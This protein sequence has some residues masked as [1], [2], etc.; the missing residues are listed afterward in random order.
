MARERE[1]TG[2]REDPVA[3]VGPRRPPRLHERG[4]RQLRLDREGEHRPLVQGVGVVNDG[5]RIPRQPHVREDVEERIR[6][7][8]RA[9][10]PSK[11]KS[12]G[13]RCSNHRRSCSGASWRNSGV[14]S[15]GSSSSWPGSLSASSTLYSTVCSPTGSAPRSGFGSMPN[16]ARGSGSANGSSSSSANGSPR[17]SGCDGSGAATGAVPAAAP[18]AG[19]SRSSSGPYSDSDPSGS[20][21]SSSSS[22]PGAS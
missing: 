6:E 2:H 21:Y 8:R 10:Q 9:G 20:S 15:S 7:L 18:A 14:S 5:E 22:A 17:G 4:L 11:S 16:G 19:D 13:G 3:V 12:R 1:L